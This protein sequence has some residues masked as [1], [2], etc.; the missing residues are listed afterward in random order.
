MNEEPWE[1]QIVNAF[2]SCLI[3]L[4]N[5]TSRTFVI[6]SS[7]LFHGKFVVEPRNIPPYSEAKIVTM[8]NGWTGGSEGSFCYLD[9]QNNLRM[10]FYWHN[11]VVGNC[12]VRPKLD[13][14]G[15][16]INQKYNNEKFMKCVCLIED[17][18]RKQDLSQS[19][20]FSSQLKL[21]SSSGSTGEKINLFGVPLDTLVQNDRL[22]QSQAVQPSED[23]EMR[24]LQAQL[25]ALEHSTD[26]CSTTPS[27]SVS[28]ASSLKSSASC[29]QSLDIPAFPQ[30]L[31]EY[32]EREGMNEKGLFVAPGLFTE[33]VE[34]RLKFQ[35]SSSESVDL[36]NYCIKSIG[37]LLKQ[38]LQEL[39][40]P[41]IPRSMVSYFTSF[42]LEKM[43]S[44]YSFED[45]YRNFML[46]LPEANRLLLLRLLRLF[47]T[48]SKDSESELTAQTLGIIF[49]PIFSP[50][51]RENYEVSTSGVV[52]FLFEKLIAN[53]DKIWGI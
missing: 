38:F 25:L 44:V 6:Q 52:C 48:L 37:I 1:K 35:T 10:H 29:S 23:E 9:E 26:S 5:N 11:P 8:N 42:E 7:Q 3:T 47:S 50:E 33:I 12:V 4:R 22:R 17:E 45:F 43:S 28:G 31:C 20:L 36:D 16:Q 51:Q 41:L 13:G 53:Y 19:N 34:L 21:A 30:I 49:G 46:D 27:A 18:E 14:P 2:R 39:P 32:L 24:L 40:A 15:L